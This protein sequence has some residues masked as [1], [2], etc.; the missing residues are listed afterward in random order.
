M[1][2][3]ARKIE[4]SLQSKGFER[5]EGDHSYFLYRTTNGK[6][7]TA[8][9]KTSHSPKMKSIGDPILGKMATQCCLT[10]S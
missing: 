8:K 4:A 1:Q 6:K 7:S 2:R 10:K 3:D 9:T 5:S